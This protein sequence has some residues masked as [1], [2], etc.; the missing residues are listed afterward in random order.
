MHRVITIAVV[1]LAALAA[2]GSAGAVGTAFPAGFATPTDASLGVPVIGFGA[3]GPVERTPLI[4]LHGN[5]DTPFPTLCNPY[6]DMHDL[7]GYLDQRPAAPGHNDGD[8]AASPVGRVSYTVG[9]MV[10][11]PAP[12]QRPARSV[13]DK[14]ASAMRMERALVTP[15]IQVKHVQNLWWVTSNSWSPAVWITGDSCP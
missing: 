11:I 7:A 4:M 1:V 10:G 6:G 3:A 13:R 15:R 9:E 2:V 5:N 8:L 14:N 12:R